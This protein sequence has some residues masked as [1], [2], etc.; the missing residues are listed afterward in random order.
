M[1]TIDFALSHS[2]IRIVK[3]T[4]VTSQSQNYVQARFDLRS[5]DWTATITAIFKADNDNNVYSMLIDKNNTCIIPWE[6]LRNTMY[7]Y[8]RR[9]D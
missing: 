5:D 7:F 2:F 4:L 8:G 6:V 9:T 1:I 3:R